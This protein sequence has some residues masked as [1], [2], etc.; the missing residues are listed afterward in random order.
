M[1]LFELQIPDKSPELVPKDEFPTRRLHTEDRGRSRSLLFDFVLLPTLQQVRLEQRL[2]RARSHNAPSPSVFGGSV[3]LDADPNDIMTNDPIIQDGSQVPEE[4][5]EVWGG[6]LDFDPYPNVAIANEA[7]DAMVQDDRVQEE[8]EEVVEAPHPAEPQPNDEDMDV[9]SDHEQHQHR[10]GL[11]TLAINSRLDVVGRGAYDIH[12][13]QPVDLRTT[14]TRALMSHL[15]GGGQQTMFPNPS[16]HKLKRGFDNMAFINLHWNPYAP[17]RPGA[18]GLFFV[19]N[20]PWTGEMTKRL[21][22]QLG[23]SK[24]LYMGLYKFIPARPLDVAEF[25]QLEPKTRLAWAN[26]LFEFRWGRQFLARIALRDENG[27][28]EPSLEEITALCSDK[29]AIKAFIDRRRVTVE[30][31]L[32]A[33]YTGKESKVGIS[34]PRKRRRRDLKLQWL[35]QTTNRLWMPR[36][37]DVDILVANGTSNNSNLNKTVKPLDNV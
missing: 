26:H 25:R 5:E 7:D 27:G 19:M 15:Y 12:N 29:T 3:D 34:Y 18:S 8:V 9:E 31:V 2:N 20:P 28:V 10:S 32:N 1:F 13:V 35:A 21:F 17:R 36:G 16:A 33:F 4:V 23:Q 14:V 6:A 11:S 22:V 37:V 24:W 30:Q